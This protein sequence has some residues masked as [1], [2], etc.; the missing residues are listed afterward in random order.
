MH[1]GDPTRWPRTDPIPYRGAQHQLAADDARKLLTM[2]RLLT[3]LASAGVVLLTILGTAGAAVAAPTDETQAVAD[4]AD[5]TQAMTAQPVA[6]LPTDVDDFQFASFSADYYLDTDDAGRSTLTTVETFVATFPEVNQNHGMRRA[7][8]ATYMGAPTDVDVQ[9]VTDAEGNARPFEVDT[10]DGFVL[11]TSADPGFLHGDQTYVFTYTQRNVTRA[12]ADTQDDEFYWDTNGTAWAQPFGEVTARVHVPS[13]LAASL[14]GDAACYRGSEGSTEQCSLTRDDG[15]GETVWETSVPG[16][17]P[18]ENVTV[19]IG[20]EP[21]TF[22][23]RDDSYFSSPLAFVQVFA[24]LVT[25]ASLVWAII[26]RRTALADGPGRPTIIAEYSP[27][28]GLDLFTAAVIMKKTTRA[29]AAAFVD[30]AVTRRIRILETEKEGWFARGTT[31]MLELVDPSGIPKHEHALAKGMFPSLAPGTDYVM[32]GK[33]TALSKRVRKTIA[34]ATTEVTSSG[35]RKKSQ[36]AKS[37][38]PAL[39]V[40][41][42]VIATFISAVILA[43]NIIGGGVPF[44]MLAVV[45]VSTI[46]VFILLGRTPLTS[47]GAELRDHLKGLE[48]YIRLAE[49]DRLRMLQSPSGALTQPAGPVA[50][51]AQAG[52]TA[53]VGTVDRGRVVN[54]YEKLLPYAVLFGLETEWAEELGKYY[55]DESPEWYSG[56]GTFNAAIFASSISSLS[57]TAASSYSGSD[58]SSSSGGSGGG[59]SSGGGGGGGGG[60]GV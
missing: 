3:T 1:P 22:V 18:Y 41:F 39:L 20:F 35:L 43:D 10:D 28:P 44:I 16:V 13:E 8:P 58:S 23:P 47:A 14:T 2:T 60:G 49:A 30:L 5:E 54:I 17:G 50:G 40:T 7:I 34:K 56:S 42:A 55:V 31:Y 26:L 57:S 52:G 27:P 48:L 21:G 24:L 45:V 15:A 33:D 6:A 19:S 51:A 32:S 4:P 25:L 38:L 59:G 11:V 12:F 9:S 36:V 46:I 29:A 37:F 53:A